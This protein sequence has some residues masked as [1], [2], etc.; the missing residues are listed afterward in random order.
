[1]VAIGASWSFLKDGLNGCSVPKRLLAGERDQA[2]AR[3]PARLRYSPNAA[4]RARGGVFIRGRPPSCAGDRAFRMGTK[5]GGV[6]RSFR[7]LLDYL[8]NLAWMGGISLH[9]RVW[10]EPGG[11][12]GSSR[13]ICW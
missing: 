7:I 6:R 1:M 4:V 11:R 8:V 2:P 5:M 3:F 9:R 10:C 13:M 12:R